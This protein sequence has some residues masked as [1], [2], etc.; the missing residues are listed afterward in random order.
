MID[1]SHNFYNFVQKSGNTLLVKDDIGKPKPSTRKLPCENFTYGKANPLDVEGA[2]KVIS[3]WSKHTVSRTQPSDRDFKK[4][5]AMSVTQGCTKAPQVRNFRMTNDFRIKTKTTRNKSLGSMQ[6]EGMRYGRPSRP[7]TPIHAVVGH[8]YTQ[9]ADEIQ[10]DAYA[11]RITNIS[12]RSINEPR[13]TKGFDLLKQAVKNSL[14][15]PVHSDFKMKKFMN[16]T[17]RTQTYSKTPHETFKKRDEYT[18]TKVNN[19]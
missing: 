15:R 2:G 11:R 18:K 8:F 19:I 7:S 16:V 3:S 9:V 4:L 13:S 5:N 10:N 1:P 17:A 6:D 12:E 14:I